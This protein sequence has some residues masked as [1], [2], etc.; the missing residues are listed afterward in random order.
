MSD[1]KLKKAKFVRETPPTEELEVHFN[2]ESLQYQVSNTLDKGKGDKKKQ[3]V[4]QSSGKLTME[5]VFDTT[6]VGKDV[7]AY[8]QKLAGFMEPGKDKIPAVVRFEWVST[9]SRACSRRS[10]RPSN[11]SIPRG[12]R[13]ARRST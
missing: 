5:V 10:R 3:Y 13:C 9:P 12:C 11:S 8:T 6:H 7:R 2:P 1:K 4:S